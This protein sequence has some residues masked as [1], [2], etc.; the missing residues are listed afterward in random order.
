MMHA[1]ARR[2]DVQCSFADVSFLGK[3]D[4][5]ERST[6]NLI[7]SLIFAIGYPLLIPVMFVADS[8]SVLSKNYTTGGVRTAS[9][10]GEDA[11]SP[12]TCC[13]CNDSTC[14]S[15]EVKNPKAE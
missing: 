2:Q 6:A 8:I 11:K 9:W 13:T 5:C 10:F 7:G 15:T 14:E 1:V 4:N 12:C 3:E